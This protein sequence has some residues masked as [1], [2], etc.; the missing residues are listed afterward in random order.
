MPMYMGHVKVMVAE[1]GVISIF[2]RLVNED[3][4]LTIFGDGE[5]TRDFVYGRCC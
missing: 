4:P 3:K 2:N 1:G 5:Q